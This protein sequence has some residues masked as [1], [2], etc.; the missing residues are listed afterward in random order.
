MVLAQPQQHAAERDLHE[1]RQIRREAVLEIDLAAEE[2]E[3][4]LP[5]FRDI[6]HPQHRDGSQKLCSHD[7][8][9]N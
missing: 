3:I 4:E 1:Q 7:S 2:V 8:L 9:A 6:E 5:G